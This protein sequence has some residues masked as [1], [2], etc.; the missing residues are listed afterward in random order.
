MPST[1][2]TDRGRIERHIK[3][4]LGRKCASEVTRADV[5]RFLRDV[6]EGK[7]KADIKIGTRG[8]A[9]VEGGRGTATRTVGLPGG[10]FSFAVAQGL[11]P[12]NPVRGVKRFP[13]RKSERFLS[14]AELAA[15]AKALSATEAEGADPAAVSIIR[16]LA[17][18]GAR[19]SEIANLKWSEIDFDR[20]LLRL[21]D[22][23][24]DKRSLHSAHR[25]WKFFPLCRARAD[26]SMFFR[27]D[28]VSADFRG[29]RKS[30]A[31]FVKRP[32]CPTSDCM[33]CGTPMR[34]WVSLRAEQPDL[35]GTS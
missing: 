25:C 1:I 21:G 10:I 8:R 11:R 28:Q 3:P 18:T 9:I 27:L 2:S 30:G 31:R 20:A 33:I 5:Q 32:A 22:S 19:K 29:S 16:L 35:T 34:A 23:K 14:S 7:T 6:A 15:F 24:T 26:L 4:L 17:F 12:D 13:D